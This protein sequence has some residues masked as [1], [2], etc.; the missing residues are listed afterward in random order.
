MYCEH[1]FLCVGGGG[2]KGG[3]GS[4]PENRLSDLASSFCLSVRP[5]GFN[6]AYSFK[7]VPLKP[8]FYSAVEIRRTCRT[9][10]H[11]FMNVRQKC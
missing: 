10:G 11:F 6:I 2:G 4:L 7:I 1:L 3:G 8:S 9:I 5:S